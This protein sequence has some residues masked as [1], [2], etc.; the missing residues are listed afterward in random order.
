MPP[1]KQ[2]QD[3]SVLCVANLVKNIEQHWIKFKNDAQIDG[4][5]DDPSSNF[6]KKMYL[7]GPFEQLNDYTV[8]LILKK[9]YQSNNFNRNYFCLCVHGRLRLA[10]FSFIKK[11]SFFN[12]LICNYL[13]KNCFVR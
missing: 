11:K 10:D 4:S 7:I 1:I 9:L 5:L 12:P 3:L 2:P 13:G 8:D 6:G